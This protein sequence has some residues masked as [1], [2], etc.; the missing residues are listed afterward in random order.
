[1]NL[2]VTYTNASGQKQQTTYKLI[3]GDRGTLNQLCI[4]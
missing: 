2:T 4:E 1:M 3:F